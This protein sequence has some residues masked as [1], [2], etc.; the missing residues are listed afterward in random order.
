MLPIELYKTHVDRDQR[1]LSS[2]LQCSIQE[3][4]RSNNSTRPKAQYAPLKYNSNGHVTGN[5]VYVP[6]IT[7]HQRKPRFDDQL[8]IQD[9]TELEKTQIE[10]IDR[11]KNQHSGDDNMG[12][13]GN[14]RRKEAHSSQPEAR[15]NTL[16]PSNINPNVFSSTR[17]DRNSGF[18]A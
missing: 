16:D 18:G 8:E 12:N 2:R 9:I 6:D 1:R 11:L 10:A 14:F 3:Q 7:G 4:I 17:S 15:R 5:S 13:L